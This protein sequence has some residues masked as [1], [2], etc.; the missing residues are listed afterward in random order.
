MKKTLWTVTLV[1]HGKA[2]NYAIFEYLKD[3][4]EFISFFSL[5]DAKVSGK[6]SIGKVN[7]LYK[8]NLI[9]K[10]NNIIKFKN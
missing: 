5:M 2:V 6:I 10:R 8:S 4:K 1:K 7:K 3:A 9:E